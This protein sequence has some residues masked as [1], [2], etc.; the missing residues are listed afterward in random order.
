MTTPQY[1][2]YPQ[3]QPTP[4]PEMAPG[5][6]PGK[7]RTYM[8][9]G[10]S[11]GIILFCI[12]YFL[13]FGYLIVLGI[14]TLIAD[15]TETFGVIIICLCIAFLL[16]VILLLPNANG[17]YENGLQTS[18]PLILRMVGKPS[19]IRYEDL[20]AVYPAVFSSSAQL[21]TPQAGWYHPSGIVGNRY[22]ESAAA[23]GHVFGQLLADSG[24][25]T[26]LAF[27]T[28]NGRSVL[29][30]SF[31]GDRR[32][33]YQQMMQYVQYS[34]GV[35]NLPLVRKPLR[36]T[37]EELAQTFNDSGDIPFK[38]YFITAALALGLPFL[39]MIVTALILLAVQPNLGDLTGPLMILMICVSTVVFVGIYM[40][41]EAKRNNAKTRLYYYY[42]SQ[43]PENTYAQQAPAQSY[44]QAPVEPEPTEKIWDPSLR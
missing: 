19:F 24:Q 41:K 21:A 15:P 23:F 18:K 36:L 44:A 25:R 26:G 34:M 33:P 1:P 6:V 11:V 13:G 39:V 30:L 35:R 29:A 20:L 8:E 2:L 3:P 5:S 40:Y 38:W 43:P 28:T 10:P 32:S 16:P 37:D 17:I 7:G 14:L 9:A 27:E 42:A 4:L 31:P 12:F 22:S